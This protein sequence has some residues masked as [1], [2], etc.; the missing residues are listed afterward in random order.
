[1]CTKGA[2][3]GDERTAWYKERIRMQERRNVIAKL[4]SAG[5]VV[6][7]LSPWGLSDLVGFLEHRGPPWVAQ[8]LHASTATDLAGLKTAMSARD[9]G[10]SAS[11]SLL[12]SGSISALRPRPSSAITA[13]WKDIRPTTVSAASLDTRQR[14]RRRFPRDRP[15]KRSCRARSRRMGL[16]PMF[17]RACT[18]F[19]RP[20]CSSSRR[21]TSG[22]R[23]MRVS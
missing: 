13:G 22:F 7:R 18:R 15:A 11:V 6:K 17:A 9:P 5:P 20:T 23:P 19:P 14:L 16:R 21:T 2:V 10:L 12:G 4:T 1:M 8:A 3:K